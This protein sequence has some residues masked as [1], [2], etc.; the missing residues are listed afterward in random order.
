M[1]QSNDK[2]EFRKKLSEVANSIIKIAEKQEDE[3][4][5]NTIKKEQY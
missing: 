3:L 2:R 4:K 1:I 5:N